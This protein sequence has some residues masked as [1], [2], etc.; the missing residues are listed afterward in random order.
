[1]N[2]A[3]AVAK[4][5]AGDEEISMS[6]SDLPPC[7]GDVVQMTQAFNNL[8]DNAVKYLDPNRRGKV[9]I[10]GWTEKDRC[11]YSVADNGVGIASSQQERVFDVLHRVRPDGPVAGEGLG[12][13]IA[14]RIVERNN[15]KIWLES[16][17][18][19]GSKFFISLP[20]A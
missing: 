10:E 13:S 9:W 2:Q 4:L 12:L 17:P 15:G 16:E 20:K 11:V 3:A 14:R 6:V 8:L 18:G 19:E 1:M 5:K 7:R